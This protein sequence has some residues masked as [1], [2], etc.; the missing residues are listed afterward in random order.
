VQERRRLRFNTV[1]E[2]RAEIDRVLAA[3]RAGTLRPSG[4][5]T[6]GQAFG[7]LAT[8]INFAY[9]GYPMRVPWFIRLLIRRKLKRYLAGEMDGGVRIPRVEGGTFGTEPLSTEEGA[10]RLRAALD[11]MLREPARHDSPAFGKLPEAQR[12]ELN[13]RHAELHLGFLHP[14]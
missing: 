8:W 9:D 4:N 14:E 1:D 2:L 10:T 11:R 6:A 5:W 7:H 3:E 12:I 13:L